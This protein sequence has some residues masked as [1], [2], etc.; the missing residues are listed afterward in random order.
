[1]LRLRQVALAARDLEAAVADCVAV[2]GVEV[3]FRDPGVAAFGL[4][5]A[6]MPLGDTFLEIVSPV[7]PETTAGRWLERRGGDA[8]YMV[9]VQTDDADSDRARMGALGVRV[10][11]SI[12]LDD[13]RGTHLHPRDVG[14]AIVSLDV[15]VPPGSWRWAGPGW[16]AM[17]RRAPARELRGVE[18]AA[19][20]PGALA[21]RW[22]EVLE[23]RPVAGGGGAY[24]VP[25][26]RGT[27]RFV[28]GGDDGVVAVDVAVADPGRVLAAARARGCI[29]ADD[30]LLCGTRV[31]LR[32][33]DTG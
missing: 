32:P 25:L 4:V 23:R 3:A 10:V 24:A 28:S 27:I 8:G 9:M 22:G 16:E 33:A 17:G 1:M 31:R 7:R 13:I 15:P 11:W 2:L 18:L 19:R 29:A 6:V 20:D 14:G 21:R 30:V 12:D 5:N 26:D